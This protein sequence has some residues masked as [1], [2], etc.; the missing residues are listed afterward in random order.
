[1]VGATL[2]HPDDELRAGAKAVLDAVNRR[3]AVLAGRS[4][5]I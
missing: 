2:V 3:L 1:L 4:G 5:Q